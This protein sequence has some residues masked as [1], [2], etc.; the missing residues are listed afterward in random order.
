MKIIGGLEISL[1]FFLFGILVAGKNLKRVS[2]IS[3]VLSLVATL[4]CLVLNKIDKIEPFIIVAI[5]LSFFID[6]VLYKIKR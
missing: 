5:I 3:A 6:T 2:L 1:L 4:L